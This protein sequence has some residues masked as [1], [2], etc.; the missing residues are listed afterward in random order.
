MSGWWSFGVSI[1]AL[2]VAT[3]AAIY[4]RKQYN[5]A[6]E[7]DR[8]T[9]ELK[10]PTLDIEPTM[11]DGRRWKL[12]IRLKN[13]SDDRIVPV[14]FAI[15]S[16]D[17]GYISMRQTEPSGPLPVSDVQINSTSRSEFSGRAIA[18]G[19]NGVWLAGYEISDAFPAKPGTK[20]TLIID[21]KYLES[22]ERTESISVTRQLN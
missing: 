12:E 15:P 8:R 19:E 2:L 17:G 18:P 11:L 9:Q 14:G 10:R 7:Q 21:V 5:L 3:T 4:T 13:K 6:Y 22:K 20:L 16:P 1:L